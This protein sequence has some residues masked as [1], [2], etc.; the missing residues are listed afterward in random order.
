MMLTALRGGVYFRAGITIA[1]LAVFALIAPPAASA[2][3][4]G[5]NALHCLTYQHNGIAKA[6]DHSHAAHQNKSGADSA[7]H[8]PDKGDHNPTCCALFLVTAL[9][10]N[11]EALLPLPWP[12]RT[13]PNPSEIRCSGRGPDQL[14]RPPISLLSI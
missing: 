10:P 7:K 12:G 2:F 13:L 3:G 1:V 5:K 14:D 6:G 8:S 4:H 11:A 9:A